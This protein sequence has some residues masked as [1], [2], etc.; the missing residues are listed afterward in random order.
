M[1]PAWY[2]LASLIVFVDAFDFALRWWR[3]R[4]QTRSAW[5]GEPGATSVP[6]DVGRWTPYQRRLHLRPWALA[7][8]VHDL[9]DAA[10]AFVAATGEHRDRLWVIDDASADGTAERLEAVGLR[11]VRGGSNRHKPGAIRELLRH[12]PAEVETILIL[13]PDTRILELARTD[14]ST[15][16]SVLFDFQRSG[17]AALC[18]R[19]TV[20]REGWLTRFQ[21]LEYALMFGVGRKSLGD[22]SITSGVAVYQ[23]DALEEALE[24]HSLSVYAEDLEN[25]LH[26]LARGERIYYDERLVAETE[27][28]DRVG[29]LFSQRV[30]WSYGLAKV[31]S[32]NARGIW[33]ACRGRPM[34]FYQYAVYLGLLGI[35]LHPFKLLSAAAL[36]ASALNGLDLVAGTALVPDTGWT[37]VWYL[38]LVWLKYTLLVGLML[39]ATLPAAERREHLPLA[40]A[41][42]FYTIA[43][44]VPVTVGF[45]N[46][47]WLR[48]AGRRL[49]RDH[50]ADD[51][52]AHG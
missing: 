26:L 43:L 23:R 10:D 14:L 16:E 1:S 18:P 11:V 50:F 40:P 47:L 4:A 25:T 46:W 9:G 49:Y 21:R 35:A 48:A 17:H 8:S 36:A 44:L 12:L 33:R 32:E 15:L 45:L 28:K 20:E 24:R 7:V 29:A 37:S 2:A 13:D 38:P 39:C 19:I 27:G 5:R 41:Y 30:G 42:L 6:L 22:Y 34:H 51:V 52:H 31:Y 3:R